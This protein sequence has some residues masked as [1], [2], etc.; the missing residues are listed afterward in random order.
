MAIKY[1]MFDQEIIDL[2]QEVAHH[3]DLMEILGKQTNRDVYI[4]LLEVA[5]F[6]N[7]AVEG[8]YSKM[9]IL[10][11]CKLLRDR[12]FQRRTGVIICH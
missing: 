5:T 9:D 4:M 12:L 10:G 2:N 11:L 3:P 8:D 7:V 1:E 6:C